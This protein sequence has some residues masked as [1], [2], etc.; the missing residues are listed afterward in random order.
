MKND[1]DQIKGYRPKPFYFLNTNK[2]ED[3]TSEKID[4]SMEAMRD[5]GFGG[6]ILFNKPPCGFTEEEFLGD[7]WFE[8]IEKFILSC[9]K[10]NLEL[11]INDG[12]NFPPGDAAGKIK[13][14]APELYQRRIRLDAAGKIEVVKVDWG[15]PAFEEEESSRLFI[16]LTYEKYQSKVGKYFGKGIAGF[17]SDAD[18]RRVLPAYLKA[19]NGER[20]YPWCRDFKAKFQSYFNYDITPYLQRLLKGEKGD[21]VVDYW[22]FV[23]MLYQNWFA[24]NHQW[25]Q[26]HKLKYSFHTSDTGFLSGLECQRSSLF[27]EGDSFDLLQHSDFPGVDHELAMLNGGVHYYKG[28]Q[29]PEIKMGNEPPSRMPKFFDTKLD[30]RAKIAFSVANLAS[31]CKRV[32]CEAYAATN[33]SSH[34]ELLRQITSWQ[35]MQGVSFFVPHAV[36]HVF[37][38]E[39]RYF[40]PPEWMHGHLK[41]GLKQFNDWLAESCFLATRGSYFIQ[42]AVLAPTEGTWLDQ[43]CSAFYDLCDLLNRR[44]VGYIIIPEGKRNDFFCV[45]DYKEKSWKIPE[46][47]AVFNGTGVVDFMPRKLDSGEVF[48]LAANIRQNQMVSGIVSMGA[49]CYQISL[50]PG[51]ICVVDKE[52]ERTDIKRAE[53]NI[54]PLWG[55]NNAWEICEK[56]TS[57][58][59]L[60]PLNCTIPSDLS[61]NGQAIV[62]GEKYH[63]CKLSTTPGKYTL[64]EKKTPVPVQ[65]SYYLRGEFKCACDFKFDSQRN[66]EIYNQKVFLPT[67]ASFRLL[68]PTSLKDT[69]IAQQGYPFY[70]GKIIYCYKLNSSSSRWL[71]HLERFSNC[72]QI[73]VNNKLLKT[74]PYESGDVLLEN[75]AVHDEI[76]IVVTP[77]LSNLLE[78]IA[79]ESGLMK[80]AIFRRI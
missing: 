30:V 28:F 57:L 19:L 80:S 52:W 40:A 38:G 13:E 74:L 69:S 21:F 59:L 70:S 3:Y 45:L 63:R 51:E 22:H 2:R 27:T 12:F 72:A 58:E 53:A 10:N 31:P 61:E 75:L 32:L 29:S 11:W 6:L 35:I 42:C 47:V 25:C 50:E 43:D 62:A 16:E 33:W 5:N 48:V 44:G 68:K 76:Q 39:I 15:F 79:C 77:M 64:A 24:K 1:E 56:L 66:Y 37:E 14:I 26:K 34:Y 20:Y 73:Y 60:V 18:N 55:E 36:H 71:L 7:F 17:F 49:K 67:N 4:V 8:V 54:I 78:G 23:G 46:P 41:E 9:K 65:S